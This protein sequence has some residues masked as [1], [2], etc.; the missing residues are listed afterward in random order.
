MTI[1]QLTLEELKSIN[2]K[3]DIIIK[4]NKLYNRFLAGIFTS[5][6]YVLGT[7]LIT[8]IVVYIISLQKIDLVGI[9][10]KFIQDSFNRVNFNQFKIY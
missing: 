8:A 4:K 7:I 9:T 10:A 6:G 3:L 2:R 1:R 5:F